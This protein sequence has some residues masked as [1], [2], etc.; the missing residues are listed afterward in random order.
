MNLRR[1]AR[2]REKRRAFVA[3]QSLLDPSCAAKSSKKAVDDASSFT[4]TS[5]AYGTEHEHAGE[6]S[7]VFWRTISEPGHTS[8]G[9][10]RAPAEDR[11][12]DK[13]FRMMRA[14]TLTPDDS[15][16]EWMLQTEAD[17]AINRAPAHRTASS[18]TVPG[19][20]SDT[21]NRH[22]G[23]EMPYTSCTSTHN[24]TQTGAGANTHTA[25]ASIGEKAS[26][27][28]AHLSSLT[29]PN[30][31]EFNLNGNFNALFT[32]A[33]RSEIEKA[34]WKYVQTQQLQQ[35]CKRAA[36]G[37][38]RSTHSEVQAERMCWPRGGK[39]E[40]DAQCVAKAA[41]VSLSV[42][43]E[44]RSVCLCKHEVRSEACVCVFL[45]VILCSDTQ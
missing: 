8:T 33:S 2:A 1:Q 42:A 44:V 41:A 36:T 4:K 13:R 10:T 9:P 24:R 23:F 43:H 20:K 11:G 37:Q 12:V 25:A 7:A 45:S 14:I 26:E 38:L 31:S 35:S 27:M 17:A 29:L 18:E 30:P 5:R 39:I 3:A 6:E 21:A 15:L 32:T 28:G 19:K 22:S 34:A 40:M 16:L